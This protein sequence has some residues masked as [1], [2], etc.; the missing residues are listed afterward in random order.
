MKRDLNI[1]FCGMVILLKHLR[2]KT[3]ISEDEHRKIVDRIARQNNVTIEIL[4][5]CL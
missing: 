5:N 4:H 3:L 2:D 1:D